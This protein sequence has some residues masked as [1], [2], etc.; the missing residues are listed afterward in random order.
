MVKHGSRKS[1]LYSLDTTPAIVQPP[2]RTN[3]NMTGEEIVDYMKT[4]QPE[5]KIG[6]IS[7]LSNQQLNA[8]SNAINRR[9][10][11]N[12]SRGHDLS[13]LSNEE[14]GHYGNALINS[15]KLYPLRNSASG[16]R[17]KKRSKRHKK[18]RGKKTRKY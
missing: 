2:S 12:S 1:K 13:H 11:A 16:K 7:S 5:A 18:K 4:I 8:W 9:A 10:A 3:S 17:N 6:F 15:Y 14:L